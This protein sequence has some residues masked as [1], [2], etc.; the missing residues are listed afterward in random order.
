[1]G[2]GSSGSLMGT[3]DSKNGADVNIHLCFHAWNILCEM[4]F[5]W[6]VSMYCVFWKHGFLGELGRKVIIPATIKE[7]LFAYVYGQD[8]S[9][10]IRQVIIATM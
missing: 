8:I 6:N 9:I 4:Y 7:P 10:G 3:T 5:K 2:T 1:M